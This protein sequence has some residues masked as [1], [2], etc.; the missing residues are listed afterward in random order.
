MVLS[1]FMVF[2][3]PHLPLT[4]QFVC[5]LGGGGAADK[6]EGEWQVSLCLVAPPQAAA[7]NSVSTRFR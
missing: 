4:F 3:G 6:L 2:G 1:V 7:D 5:G